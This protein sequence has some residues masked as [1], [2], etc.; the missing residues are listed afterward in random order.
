LGKGKVSFKDELA[1]AR[2]NGLQRKNQPAFF[3]N[4]GGVMSS[5]FNGIL[6]LLVFQVKWNGKLN[7]FGG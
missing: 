7:C 6:D 5:F 2:F 1:K 3:T 4:A